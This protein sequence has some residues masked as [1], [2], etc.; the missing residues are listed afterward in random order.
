MKTKSLFALSTA[1]LFS[2]CASIVSKSEYP[3]SLTSS[4]SGCKVA[5]KKNGMTVYQGLTPSIV[6]L[7]ASNGF[8][9]PA[10]YQIEFTKKGSATQII[11]ITAGIDGWYI[12]NLLFGGLIGLIVVDPA[13]GAMWRLPENVSAN[14]T[15]LA[16]VTGDNGK[17]LRIAD[18]SSVPASIQDQLVAIR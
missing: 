15:P 18:R 8:F 14:M 7:T 11:P 1:V 4:P 9:Q 5:V 10:N 3:V 2:S 12:G 13:T 6:T 17:T 16:S